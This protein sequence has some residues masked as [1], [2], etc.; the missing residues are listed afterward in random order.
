MRK[1]LFVG[2]LVLLVPYL[3]CGGGKSTS[4]DTGEDPDAADVDSDAD[5]GG[6]ADVD[7]GW[8]AD[9]DGVDAD[10]AVMHTVVSLTAGGGRA[11]SPSYQLTLGIGAPQPMGGVESGTQQVRVGPGAGLNQ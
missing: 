6:D 3:G 1:R 9:A 4:P 11:E 7:G 2:S 5:G 10:A 8:D